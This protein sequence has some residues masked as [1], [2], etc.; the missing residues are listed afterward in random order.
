LAGL[1]AANTLHAGHKEIHL[2][3]NLPGM[4]VLPVVEINLLGT[5]DDFLD[6][7]RVLSYISS[8]VLLI[9]S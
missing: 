6:V 8:N 5:V 7:S 9:S 1:W 4:F 2:K 3:H